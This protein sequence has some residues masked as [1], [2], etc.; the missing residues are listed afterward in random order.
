MQTLSSLAP[1]VT[2]TSSSAILNVA[3]MHFSSPDLTECNKLVKLKKG[4]PQ[5]K[6]NCKSLTT[7]S[8]LFAFEREKKNWLEKIKNKKCKKA[9]FCRLH[10][11][12]S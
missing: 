10:V 6:A 1:V 3:T 9:N 5:V 11:R 4:K 7:K 8:L 12:L 2:K